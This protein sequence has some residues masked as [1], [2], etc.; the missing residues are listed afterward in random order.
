MMLLRVLGWPL[1]L[2]WRPRSMA[3]CAWWHCCGA[4]RG[5]RDLTRRIHGDIFADGSCARGAIHELN[6]SCWAF[7]AP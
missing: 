5:R 7:S 6:R 2:P 1:A 4:G 3:R